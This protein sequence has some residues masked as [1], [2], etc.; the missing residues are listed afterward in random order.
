ML[1]KVKVTPLRVTVA[2]EATVVAKVKLVVLA[3]IVVANVLVPAAMELFSVNAV[4][5]P[6]VALVPYLLSASVMTDPVGTGAV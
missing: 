4:L 1:W 6:V 5:S 2:P 3:S